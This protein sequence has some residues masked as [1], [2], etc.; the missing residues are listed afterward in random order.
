MRIVQMNSGR[1]PQ[2]MPG[3]RMLWIVATKFTAP[4]SD[5]RPVRWTM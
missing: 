5:D 1:R 3:A 2:P 4:I